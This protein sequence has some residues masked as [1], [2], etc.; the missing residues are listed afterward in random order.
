MPLL[1]L[2]LVHVRDDAVATGLGHALDRT[3]RNL[4]EKVAGTE[5][6]LRPHRRAGAI[7]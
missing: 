6:A 5:H 3:H 1:H 4:R 2:D 7:D